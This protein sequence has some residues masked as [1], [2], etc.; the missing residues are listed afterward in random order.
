M[1]PSIYAVAALNMIAF[2]LSVV[3]TETALTLDF[4]EL[5]VTASWLERRHD[6]PLLAALEQVGVV[7]CGYRL[8]ADPG[9]L[10]AL[11]APLHEVLLAFGGVPAAMTLS[12]RLVQDRRCTTATITVESAV[13]SLPGILVC[14]LSIVFWRMARAVRQATGRYRC[15]L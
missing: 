11:Q 14:L 4:A 10:W 6:L 2:A 5:V 7:V 3:L 1:A 12:L 15:I 13:W 9:G 8:L